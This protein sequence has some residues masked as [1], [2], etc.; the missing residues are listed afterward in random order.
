MQTEQNGVPNME[1]NTV[2]QQTRTNA[3]G[4]NVF[5]GVSA[6]SLAHYVLT[7]NKTRRAQTPRQPLV[8][9]MRWASCYLSRKT[10][11]NVY[12]I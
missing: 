6:A 11:S 8:K 9:A 5:M 12:D 4:Q 10:R 3:F 2:P 7:A 1:P